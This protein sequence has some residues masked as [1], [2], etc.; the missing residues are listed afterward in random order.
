MIS[1]SPSRTLKALLTCALLNFGAIAHAQQVFRAARE[2]AGAD[3][4]DTVARVAR[5]REL[6]LA[7]HDDRHPL[8]AQRPHQVQVSPLRTQTG[9]DDGGALGSG[10][11]DGRGSVHGE[12]AE[13][14]LKEGVG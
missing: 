12:G 7:D 10:G 4:F 6:V 14:A 13:S 9:Q 1:L 11:C 3:V 2:V 5:R 8:L